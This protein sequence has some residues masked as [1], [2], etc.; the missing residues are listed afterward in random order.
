MLIKNGTIIDGSGSKRFAADIR[1]ENKKIKETGRL[2]NKGNEDVLDAKGLYIT[3]GFVDVLNHSD[4]YATLFSNPEQE[5]LLQQGVTTI[6]MGNC[7]ASL[8][9]LVDGVFVNSV[10]K[11]GRV[12]K[13]N[14]NWLSVAEYLEELKKHSF[15]VNVA[16]LIG[17]STIRRALS[18]DETR[19]LNNFEQKQLEYMVET[20]MRDGAFGVSSGLAYSHGATATAKEL[21][22]IMNIVKS[23]NGLYSIHIRNEADR[24]DESVKEILSLVKETG[25]NTEL[26]HFKVVEKKFWENFK[27]ALSLIEK[28]KNINFDIYPYNFTASVLYSFLPAWAIKNG[29]TSLLP[30][31]KDK[32]KKAELVEDMKKDPYS[33][34]E[35]TVAMGSIAN[36]YFGRKI[37]DIAKNQEKEVEEVVLDLIL[38]SHNR[39][40]VFSP[41]ID[42][43]NIELAIKNPKSFVSSDGV[44]YKEENRIEAGF[45]H[46]RYFGAFPKF[47]NEYVYNKKLISWE[48]AINKITLGPA[49][50]IGLKDRGKIKKGYFADLVIFNPKKLQSN[51]DLNNPYQYPSGIHWV[52][53]NGQVA[54]KDKKLKSK[55]GTVLIRK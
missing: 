13:I 19:N 52:L 54:I 25:V 49:Q 4:A 55:A 47:L 50:K 32:V 27:G 36:T 37:A 14:V 30:A 26:S 2:N 6:L 5:S 53:V 12:S 8:A 1:I 39:L 29:N 20:G 16:T 45:A 9:P 28:L 42:E 33:Y 38:A 44:G 15:G 40:I 3:P 7:G 43:S 21:R 46:P 11:W 18:G 51:S 10:Q 41:S 34:G 35:M 48:E 24:F 23:Y 31:I 17:H 22:A